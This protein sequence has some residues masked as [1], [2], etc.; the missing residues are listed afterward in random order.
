MTSFT[1]FFLF[2]FNNA[3]KYRTGSGRKLPKPLASQTRRG[4]FVHAGTWDYFFWAR[5]GKT[6]FE[7]EARGQKGQIE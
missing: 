7:D 2:S 4:G 3:K 1:V 6:Q 5:Y